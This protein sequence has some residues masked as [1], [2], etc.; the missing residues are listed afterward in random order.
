MRQSVK[1]DFLLI[2]NML[3]F[4]WMLIFGMVLSSAAVAGLVWLLVRIIRT[5]NA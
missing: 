4:F 1:E 3:Q 5:F 2:L